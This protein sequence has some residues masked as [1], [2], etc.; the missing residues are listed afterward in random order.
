MSADVLPPLPWYGVVMPEDGTAQAALEDLLT[1]REPDERALRRLI[2]GGG[3]VAYSISMH[4]REAERFVDRLVDLGAV[5][6]TDFAFVKGEH[7]AYLPVPTWLE[8][9]TRVDDDWVVLEGERLDA[10]PLKGFRARR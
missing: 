5:E 7:G 1:R 9:L 10:G 6:G 2:R 4:E 8:Q 3:L